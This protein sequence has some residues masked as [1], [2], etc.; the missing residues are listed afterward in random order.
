M[1]VENGTAEFTHA[2][3]DGEE[4]YRASVSTSDH[5]KLIRE[6]NSLVDHLNGITSGTESA[7]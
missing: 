3:T 2:N 7:R 4:V 1:K 6:A 5:D